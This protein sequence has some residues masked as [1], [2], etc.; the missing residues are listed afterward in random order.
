MA[1]A[2]VVRL[3]LFIQKYPQCISLLLQR[4]D[5]IVCRSRANGKTKTV[6]FRALYE[7]N[8]GF[9]QVQGSWEYYLDSASAGEIMERIREHREAQA[10]PRTDAGADA[11]DTIGSA[12]SAIATGS[13]EPEPPTP[14]TSPSDVAAPSAPAPRDNFAGTYERYQTMDVH[15]RAGLLSRSHERLAALADDPNAAP[16]EVAEALIE[17]TEQATMANRATLLEALKMG[18]EEAR[19]YSTEMVE[20]TDEMVRTTIRLV[21]S[22]VYDDDLVSN[23]VQKSNG[24]VVQHMTRVFLRGLQ[25]L[26]YYNR[27]VIRQGIASR[28]RVK[29]PKRYRGAYGKLLPHIDPDDLTLERVF[30]GGM[31]SLSPQEIHAFATGF[32]VHDV[33]KAEDIEYHEGEQGYDRSI[34]E[35]HVKIGYRAVMDKSNYPREAALITGHHHEYYG[36]PSGYGYFREFLQEYKNANP[37]AI[38]NYVMSY[39]ME[40]MIDYEVLAFFPAKALE[41]V[42]VFDSLTDPNRKYREPLAD[43]VALNM[44]RDEFVTKR[45]KLDPILFDLFTEFYGTIRST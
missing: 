30:Y 11:T 4:R 20:A 39:T 3:D 41:V 1:A 13:S 15:E 19:R 35:R 6:Q 32:L 10:L 22:E 7:N 27:E 24:T 17:S 8:R 31:K 45:L 18:N 36:D 38:Q 12:G 14:E 16:E 34:V 42:D 33:G 23:L 9:W 25:F 5:N 44:M 40:P 43:S 26:L 29:F 21:D 37:E 2:K 28:I